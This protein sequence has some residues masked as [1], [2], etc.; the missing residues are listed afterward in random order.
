MSIL[1]DNF[2]KTI[3]YKY[4]MDIYQYNYDKEEI[5]DIFLRLRSAVICSKHR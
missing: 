5:K 4:E 1:L 2:R 3:I